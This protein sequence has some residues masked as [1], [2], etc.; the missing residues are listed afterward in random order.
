MRNKKGQ[1]LKGESASPKTQFKKGEHWREK[2]I[3]R[4]KEWLYNEYIEL[5]RSSSDIA[6][7]FNVSDSAILFW[8]K[9]HEIKT[10]TISEAR[11]KKHW[12]QVGSD[13]PMWNRMGELNPRWLG[14][15]TPERQD[16]YTSQ[17]WKSA[18]RYVW[19][20]DNATCQRCKLE[21]SGNEDMPFHIHHIQSFKVK[22]LRAEVN[23]LVLVCEVCHHFIH[24]KKNTN[25]EFI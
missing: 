5:S 15:I 1:F 20:R 21:K 12:G 16:F 10:R 6:K 25:G 17:E 13:N 19:K 14:G 24:S 2:Q 18:C 3:F 7:Q 8:L 9:K 11:D 4:N 22:E 23:N